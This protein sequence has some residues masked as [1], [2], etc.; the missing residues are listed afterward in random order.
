M[1]TLLRIVL[2]GLSSPRERKY[3]SIVVK[4]GDSSAG[5]AMYDAAGKRKLLFLDLIL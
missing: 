2:T 3:F 5:A 1:N 4:R